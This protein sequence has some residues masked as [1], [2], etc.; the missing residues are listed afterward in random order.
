VELLVLIDTRKPAQPRKVALGSSY[1]FQI[2]HE[3]EHEDE[4]DLEDDWLSLLELLELLLNR[5]LA[6]GYRLLSL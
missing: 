3:D 5:L 1:V 6:I 4:H 2:E